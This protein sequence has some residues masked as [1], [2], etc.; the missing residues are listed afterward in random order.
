MTTTW[1]LSP[2]TLEIL[3]EYPDIIES[4]EEDRKLPI[5]PKD[6]SPKLIEFYLDDVFYASLKQGKLQE[7]RDYL[8]LNYSKFLEIKFDGE[9]ALFLCGGEAIV[10][11]I[12][13]SANFDEFLQLANL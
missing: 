8:K 10:N 6:Y 12:S 4:L 1:N 3:K 5:L 7:L 13:D 11:R 2:K 9:C